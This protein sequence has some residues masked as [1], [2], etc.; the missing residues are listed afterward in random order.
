M[1]TWVLLGLRTDSTQEIP[2]ITRLVDGIVSAS[3]ADD[4]IWDNASLR[5]LTPKIQELI[6]ALLSL[7]SDEEK[8][9]LMSDKKDSM[10]IPDEIRD[11]VERVINVMKASPFF[12]DA[13]ASPWSHLVIAYILWTR[14]WDDEISPSWL[15]IQEGLLATPLAQQ[16]RD[17]I[18]A[19]VTFMKGVIEARLLSHPG[20]PIEMLSLWCWQ[21][22]DVEALLTPAFI[23]KI[24]DA[25]SVVH[26]TLVDTDQT[27]LD[28]SNKR[29]EACWWG[30][31]I[32]VT[33]VPANILN[34]LEIK[35]AE[36][37]LNRGYDAVVAGGL[38]DY[39]PPKVLGWK[40]MPKVLN[41]MKKWWQWFFTNI[42]R[43]EVWVDGGALEENGVYSTQQWMK[44]MIL[45]RWFMNWH[46]YHRNS[47]DLRKLLSN[48]LDNILWEPSIVWITGNVTNTV[49]FTRKS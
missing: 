15:A 16:H 29:I 46:M 14:K 34:Y 12:R 25:R 7:L 6:D 48:I 24:Q 40:I 49:T 17:K 1:R 5:E 3:H 38:F 19:Q 39:F 10:S 8:R 21:S 2:G 32:K 30:E 9:W 28:I 26:F 47:D 45:L 20:I 33:L 36:N 13:R 11:R 4:R 18:K 42:A 31:N 37:S 22:P 27:W 35:N 23:Q 41:A 43:P 44:D